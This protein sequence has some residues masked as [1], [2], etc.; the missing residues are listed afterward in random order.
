MEPSTQPYR[1]SWMPFGR[2]GRTQPRGVSTRTPSSAPRRRI[3][4]TPVQLQRS[5]EPAPDDAVAAATVSR[6]GQ[7]G[8]GP[9]AMP[10]GPVAGPRPAAATEA[11]RA[12]TPGLAARRP[13]RPARPAG[14]RTAAA[15]ATAA[16]ATTSTDGAYPPGVLPTGAARRAGR[17][18]SRVRTARARTAMPTRVGDAV[19]ALRSQPGGAPAAAGTGSAPPPP[20][21]L[22]LGRTGAPRTAPARTAPARSGPPA[23]QGGPPPARGGSG[24]SQNLSFE[25]LALGAFFVLFFA[26]PVALLMAIAS[27][28]RAYQ[29]GLSPVLSWIAL[30]VTGFATLVSLG[31]L[32]SVVDAVSGLG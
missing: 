22:P 29:R 15:A 3:S 4:M 5:M 28:R 17:R 32:A 20:P 19:P 24:T 16:L 21:V 18:T 31:F 26:P 11:Y 12:A 10:S 23:P 2:T 1:R 30:L 25:P 27:V 7:D 9:A 6:A 13:P 8:G 14:S